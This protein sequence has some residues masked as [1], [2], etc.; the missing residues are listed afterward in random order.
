V[1]RQRLIDQRGLSPDEADARLASQPRLDD[2]RHLIDRVIYN[3]GSL[4]E[5]RRQ[6][7]AAWSDLLA[8]HGQPYVEKEN[9]DRGARGT[10]E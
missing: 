10:V 1:Q 2:W 6:V 9:E 8:R 4:D 3:T 7:Q 5:T